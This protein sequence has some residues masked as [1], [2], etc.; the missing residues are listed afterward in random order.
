MAERSTLADE[1]SSNTEGHD[2]CEKLED[3]RGSDSSRL[4]VDG[5]AWRLMK[6]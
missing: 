1:S 5:S 2:G 6:D 3:A 4:H